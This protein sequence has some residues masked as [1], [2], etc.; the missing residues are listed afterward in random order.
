MQQL[1]VNYLFAYVSPFIKSKTKV[2]DEEL[3]YTRRFRL[4][5]QRTKCKLSAPRAPLCFQSTTL[6]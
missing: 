3:R 6:K 2:I 4:Y 5:L 1:E